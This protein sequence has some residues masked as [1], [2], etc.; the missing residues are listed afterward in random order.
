MKRILITIFT[1]TSLFTISCNKSN[2]TIEP[3]VPVHPIEG[4]PDNELPD[5]TPENPVPVDPGYD[6]TPSA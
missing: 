3:I 2:D 5:E 1:L 6:Y 4:V